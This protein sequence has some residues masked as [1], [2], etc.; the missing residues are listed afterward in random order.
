MNS[1]KNQKIIRPIEETIYK[2]KLFP[3]PNKKNLNKNYNK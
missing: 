3:I 1:S 2:V